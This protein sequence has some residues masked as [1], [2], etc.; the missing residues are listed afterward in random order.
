MSTA[1]NIYRLRAE[2]MQDVGRLLCCIHAQR[3]E[4]VGNPGAPD[5]EVT[6]THPSMMGH[7]LSLKDMRAIISGIADGHVMW[8]TLAPVDQYT[9]A[10]TYSAPEMSAPKLAERFVRGAPKAD[11]VHVLGAQDVRGVGST[12]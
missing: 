11:R 12:R 6:I 5:V 7:A 1:K 10:R 8:E 4:I 2:C 3:V 9:G